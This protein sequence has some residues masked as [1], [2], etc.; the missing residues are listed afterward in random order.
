MLMNELSVKQDDG[1][2]TILYPHY[3]EAAPKGTVLVLHGMA[4]H[5]SRYLE[6]TA[7]LNHCGY[8]VF[9][10]D[11]RGHGT[12]KKLEELG[13][14]SDKDG[15]VKVTTDAIHLIHFIKKNC[16]NKKLFLFAHSMGSLIARNVIQHEDD[17]AGV[18]ISGTAHQ[19]PATVALGQFISSAIRTVKGHD[20][21]SPFMH[22]LVFPPKAFDSVCE[23]TKFDWLTRNQNLVGQYMNDPYCGFLCSIGLYND[24]IR[25]MKNITS[26]HMVRR[27]RK[28]L[29]IYIISGK[30]DPVCNF[31]N[32]IYHYVSLLQK[33]GFT[34]VECTIYAECRHEL[35][36][37]LNQKE[38]LLGIIKWLNAK[39][40]VK[41]TPEANVTDATTE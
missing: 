27:T 19:M 6:F 9:L 10:Y 3:T 15:D 11:H 40:S 26:P 22:N 20:Y 31:G 32:D 14:F 7:F 37:E 35:I 24:T 34:S 4:E 18:I 39:A 12:D 36:N 33:L 21:V 38:V 25:I 23:R 16:R 8:D 29:P 5:H 17:I 2:T 41:E 13:I 1:Y 28:D 30:N